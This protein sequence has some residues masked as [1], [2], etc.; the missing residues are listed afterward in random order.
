MSIMDSSLQSLVI[1]NI[2]PCL[3]VGNT[4]ALDYVMY[5]IE[6]GK[7]V[8][9]P[10]QWRIVQAAKEPFHRA[11]LGYRGRAPD[12]AH[13]EYYYA[14]RG[15]KLILN[16]IDSEDEKY[17]ENEAIPTALNFI[18]DSLEDGYAVLVH[19]NQGTS[20]APSIALL[21]LHRQGLGG[22]GEI[23]LDSAVERFKQVYPPYAPKR[24]V[25]EYLKAHW[26]E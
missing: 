23:D 13:P 20:R 10:Q 21:Y 25:Y 2:D 18:K 16:L 24:G 19:C 1:Y 12:K 15:N 26:N 9:Y 3:F 17:F 11:A 4:S 5:E 14:V 8:E 6:A 7:Q 22:C